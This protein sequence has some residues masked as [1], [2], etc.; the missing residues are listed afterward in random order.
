M[1]RT[2]EVICVPLMSID[3]LL[4]YIECDKTLGFQAPD[5]ETKGCTGKGWDSFTQR[6]A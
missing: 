5:S 4:H 2:Y 1:K 6:D 3:D